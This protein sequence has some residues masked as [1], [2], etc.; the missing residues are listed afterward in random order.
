MRFIH[1][2]DVHLGAK[3]EQQYSW[4]AKRGQE[5][6]DTFRQVIVWWKPF[7]IGL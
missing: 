5:I 3:P 4:S 7:Q 2:A 6:W 1:L